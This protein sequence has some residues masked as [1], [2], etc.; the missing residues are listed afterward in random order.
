VNGTITEMNLT[1]PIGS[2]GSVSL[3]GVVGSLVSG[4][5]DTLKVSL[6][7]GVASGLKGGQWRLVADGMRV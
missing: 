1:T 6:V 2:S 3:P 4:N 7:D 5:N